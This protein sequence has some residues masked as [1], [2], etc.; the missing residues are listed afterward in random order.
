MLPHNLAGNCPQWLESVKKK[1]TLSH[2]QGD[3]DEG[4]WSG[5]PVWDRSCFSINMQMLAIP[6]PQQTG[7]GL[8][9]GKT[10]GTALLYQG[11][12]KKG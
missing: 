12:G 1:E 5:S 4:V 2:P 7:Q 9:L 6:L 11:G 10:G 3:V 8:L